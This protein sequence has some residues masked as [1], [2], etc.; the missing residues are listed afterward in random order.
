MVGDGVVWYEVGW[1]FCLV[2]FVWLMLMIDVVVGCIVGCYFLYRMW[3]CCLVSFDVCFVM[4]IV[5]VL[6]SV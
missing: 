5:F 1:D 6:Y 2:W 3:W 4:L